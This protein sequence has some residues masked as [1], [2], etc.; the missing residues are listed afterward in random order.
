MFISKSLAKAILHY[1]FKTGGA[2]AATGGAATITDETRPG[3]LPAKPDTRPRL[4]NMIQ[5]QLQPRPLMRPPVMPL[6]D[7]RGP[8]R[9]TGPPAVR[10]HQ[11]PLRRVDPYSDFY[12]PGAGRGSVPSLILIFFDT[13]WGFTFRYRYSSIKSPYCIGTSTNL[14]MCQYAHPRVSGQLSNNFV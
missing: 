9:F 11:V 10:G 3:L 14:K 6:R 2:A 8:A 13:F 5:E 1:S 7:Q 4:I 12:N